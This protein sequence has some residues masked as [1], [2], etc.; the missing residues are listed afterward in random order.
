MHTANCQKS[1][2]PSMHGKVRAMVSRDSSA[3]ATD[4]RDVEMFHVE[5]LA[6]AEAT[7]RPLTEHEAT[8]M[9]THYRLLRQWSRKMNLTGLKDRRSI[10]RR[11]FLEPIRA[12][13]LMQGVGVC[14]DI[15]SGNGFPAV[16]LAILNPGMRL[17]MVEASE[18]KCAFLWAVVRGIGLKSAQVVT[19]RVCRRADLHGFLPARWVTF[20][21]VKVGQLLHDQGPALLEAGGRMLAFVS[22][23]DAQGLRATPPRGLRWVAD[24]SL[25]ESPGDVVAVFEMFHV[26]QFAG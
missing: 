15:G 19:R 9:V 2:R 20:R 11:H 22:E 26:E 12:S 7:A 8:G 18:K 14:V 13:D 10:L 6:G 23:G 16:P 17:V 24:K 21:G 1:S 5:L 3:G 25:P 4:E